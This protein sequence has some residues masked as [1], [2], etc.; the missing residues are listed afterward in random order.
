[1]PPFLFALLTTSTASVVSLTG[2]LS[3]LPITPFTLVV[4]A[5][6]VYVNSLLSIV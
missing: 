1:M 5:T 6:G 4:L 3:L 2:S